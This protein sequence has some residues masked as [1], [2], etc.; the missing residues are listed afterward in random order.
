MAKFMRAEEAIAYSDGP[1]T[2]SSAIPAFAKRGDILLVDE[3]VNE[4]IRTGVNLSRSHVHVFRHNDVAHLESIMKE[5]EATDRRKKRRKD[6]VR[7]FI[8]V[9][10]LYRNKGTIAP[11]PRIVQL[12]NKYCYR[13]ILD[14]S[15]A[16]GVLGATGR[17]SLEHFGL[18]RKEAEILTL[19]MENSLGSVGGVCVGSH[20][21]VDHQRLSG[22]GYCF[23]ASTPPF[24]CA[25]AITALQRIES[26][27]DL[28]RRLE[29]NA[30]KLV[31]KLNKRGSGLVIESTDESPI[32][33]VRPT[34]TDSLS[35]KEQLRLMERWAD[36]CLAGGLFVAV[37]RFDGNDIPP[38]EADAIRP[39]LRLSVNADLTEAEI[40]ST[41]QIL[42]N[43]RKALQL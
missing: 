42:L 33:V 7:R 23:S 37:N 3:C 22:A 20:T 11:L 15:Y 43:T 29:S 31:A 12:K 19:S 13:L 18:D 30:K 40:E 34:D 2:V 1:S 10:G 38:V 17:G 35:R 36:L 25:A 14:D 21:V 16:F 5:L 4:A 24:L 27:P 28:C 6:E 8:I 26:N 32:V 9:E 39:S 41:A